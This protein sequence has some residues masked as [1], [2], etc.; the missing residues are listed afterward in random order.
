[1]PGLSFAP[2]TDETGAQLHEAGTGWVVVVDH[3]PGEQPTYHPFGADDVEGVLQ[4]PT[5]G[6]VVEAVEGRLR[7]AG[8]AIARRAEQPEGT[9]LAM[10]ELRPPTSAD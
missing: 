3:A 2:P 8:F 10:W 1:M 4:P 5:R 7:A 9:V 6:A